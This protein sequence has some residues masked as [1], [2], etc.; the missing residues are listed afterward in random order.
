ML[1]S[2]PRQTRLSLASASFL[3]LDSVRCRAR[4]WASHGIMCFHSNTRAVVIARYSI[5]SRAVRRPL[6]SRVPRPRHTYLTASHPARNQ[7]PPME[8][9]DERLSTPERYLVRIS[10]R[11]P[12][13]YRPYHCP[14]E[15]TSR[16]RSGCRLAERCADCSGRQRRLVTRHCQHHLGLHPL[17]SALLPALLA[18]PRTHDI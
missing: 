6:S 11:L 3:Y 5:F 15:V 14:P 8:S 17:P 10:S 2:G 7:D 4:S 12:R 1:R 9:F 16:A 18:V 13:L